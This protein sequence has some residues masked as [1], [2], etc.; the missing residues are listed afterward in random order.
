MGRLR[1]VDFYAKEDQDHDG[2]TILRLE[3]VY[4]DNGEEPRAKSVSAL[5]RDIRL[6]L[7]DRLPNTFPVFRFLTAR[8]RANEAH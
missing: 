1:I 2:D 8:D 6:W 4:D 7:N 5:A 3:I